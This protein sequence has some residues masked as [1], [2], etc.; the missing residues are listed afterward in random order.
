MNFP[1]ASV[2]KDLR[3]YDSLPVTDEKKALNE[4]YLNDEIESYEF[5]SLA[6][7]Y[8]GKVKRGGE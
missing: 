1:S 3:E 5:H 8:M 6:M 4:R 2:L 7:E